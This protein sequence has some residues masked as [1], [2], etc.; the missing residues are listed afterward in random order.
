MGADLCLCCIPAATMSNDRR[1]RLHEIINQMASDEI[2]DFVLDMVE[3][4][5]ERDPHAILHEHVALLPDPGSRRDITCFRHRLMPYEMMY[6]GG[7]SWG[8]SPTEIF[9]SIWIVGGCRQLYEQLE[10]WAQADCGARRENGDSE[11]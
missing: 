10:T 2:P 7:L 8:D 1:Q 6:T 5:E 3:Y 4:E 11:S 9:D